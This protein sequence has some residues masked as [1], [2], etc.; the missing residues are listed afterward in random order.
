MATVENDRESDA[1][2]V[3]APWAYLSCRSLHRLPW[4]GTRRA[5][6]GAAEPRLAR[7]NPEVVIPRRPVVQFEVGRPT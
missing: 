4:S 2:E 6:S 7:E 3:P 5:P 1:D